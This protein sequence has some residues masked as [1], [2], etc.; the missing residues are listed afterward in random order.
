MGNN[1]TMKI[2]VTMTSWKKRIDYI[3]NMIEYFFKTQTELPDIFYL[4]LDIP[5][6]PNKEDDLPKKL[7]DVIKKY[8]IRLEW[9]EHNWGSFKRWFV[10]PKHYNDIVISIDDDTTYKSNLVATSRRY[11]FPNNEVVQ[12]TPWGGRLLC[13]GYNINYKVYTDENSRDPQNVFI[14]QAIFPPKSF[15]IECVSEDNVVLKK[16]INPKTDEAWVFAHLIKNRTIVRTLNLQQK[17]QDFADQNPQVKFNFRRI[18]EVNITYKN[19]MWILILLYKEDI[20]KVFSTVFPE[21]NLNE[22][23]KKYTKENLLNILLNN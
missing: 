10:Y 20:L 22:L 5:E 1:Y 13:K 14:S 18:K 2:V 17:Q 19:L 3:A 4:W 15:P 8:N 21:F 12:I 9:T 16:K 7:L 6:F 11:I 23:K